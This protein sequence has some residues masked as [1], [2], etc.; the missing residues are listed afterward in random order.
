MSLTTPHTAG[1]KE[2]PD[3]ADGEADAALRLELVST[4]AALEDERQVLCGSIAQGS[5]ALVGSLPL[6]GLH[7]ASMRTWRLAI[8]QRLLQVHAEECQRL[9]T[10]AA[11]ARARASGAA[12]S[13]LAAAAARAAEQSARETMARSQR[14]AA[15]FYDQWRLRCISC[16]SH[17]QVQ[18]CFQQGLFM[19]AITAIFQPAPCRTEA[20]EERAAFLEVQSNQA[21][22]AAQDAVAQQRLHAAAMH[23]AL[24]QMHEARKLAAWQERRIADLEG[25]NAYQ[26]IARCA[27]GLDY[28][29]Q[30]TLLRRTV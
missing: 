2:Q 16:K 15:E 1:E 29:M 12:R 6:R 11:V 25:S 23:S 27:D 28:F 19:H 20:A 13:D 21:G 24:Q 18:H 22:A 17:L 14:D 10:E 26:S 4:K 7:M 9:A 3:R 30:S 5:R 8:G